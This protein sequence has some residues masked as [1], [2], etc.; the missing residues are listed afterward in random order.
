MTRIALI[1]E[2]VVNLLDFLRFTVIRCQSLQDPDSG[3]VSPSS[4]A[5]SPEYGSTCYYSCKKGYRLNGEPIA[6]CLSNGQW[7][8]ATNVSCKG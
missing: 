7:S 5:V 4:C 6:S 8:K 3:H 2:I 1:E